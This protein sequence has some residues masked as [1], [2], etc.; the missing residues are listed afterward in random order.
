MMSIA[1]SVLVSSWG[2]RG[3][4]EFIRYSKCCGIFNVGVTFGGLAV[5]LGRADSMGYEYAGDANFLNPKISFFSLFFFFFVFSSISYPT[6]Y[7]LTPY[8]ISLARHSY[9]YM[10]I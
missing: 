3:G 6:L 2:Y 7:L 9:S 1:T 4:I 5:K 10:C 8:F